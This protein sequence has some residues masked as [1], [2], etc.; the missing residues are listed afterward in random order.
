[1]S[2][3]ENAN[4]LKRVLNEFP[5]LSENCAGY[6]QVTMVKMPGFLAWLAYLLMLLVCPWAKD[7]VFRSLSPRL[8]MMIIIPVPPQGIV[9]VFQGSRCF[10]NC[11]VLH[12]YRAF[13]I[14]SLKFLQIA[15]QGPSRLEQFGSSTWQLRAFINSCPPFMRVSC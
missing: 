2:R 9:L 6:D 7:L 11:K 8:Y 14:E 3:V 1:M 12:K 10:E 13:V 15:K 4:T 5:G